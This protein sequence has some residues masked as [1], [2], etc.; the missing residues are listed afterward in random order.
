MLKSRLIVSFVL[1]I[2]IFMY[3]THIFKKSHHQSHFFFCKLSLSLSPYQLQSPWI[4]VFCY[5]LV[6]Q[7]K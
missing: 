2:Y 6:E 3:I 4:C 1:Y 5:Q 7:I